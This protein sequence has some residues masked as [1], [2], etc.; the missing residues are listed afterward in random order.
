MCKTKNDQKM[1]QKCDY[2]AKN[3]QEKMG[4]NAFWWKIV[5][6]GWSSSSSKFTC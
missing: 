1:V 5:D 6:G 3:A 2:L 4:Y